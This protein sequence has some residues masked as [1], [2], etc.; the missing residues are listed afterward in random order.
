MYSP[1]YKTVRWLGWRKGER[2]T[3]RKMNVFTL[4]FYFSERCSDAFF[5]SVGEYLRIV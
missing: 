1:S 5:D 2:E 3:V 4:L